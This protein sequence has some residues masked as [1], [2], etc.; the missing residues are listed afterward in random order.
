MAC[1]G[2]SSV[3]F[4]SFFFLFLEN[5]FFRFG[6]DNWFVWSLNFS[7]DLLSCEIFF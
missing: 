7:G 3:F 4:L 2:V 1:L 6:F 5:Y